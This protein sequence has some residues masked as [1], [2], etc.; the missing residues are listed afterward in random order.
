M[1]MILIQRRFYHTLYMN[2]KSCDRNLK[3][4]L[5][6]GLFCA[7]QALYIHTVHLNFSWV[8]I[9]V[10]VRAFKGENNMSEKKTYFV[11]VGWSLIQG[12]EHC[13][14]IGITSAGWRRAYNKVMNINIALPC[15]GLAHARA[16]EK[17]GQDYLETRTPRAFVKWSPV[18][19]EKSPNRTWDWWI[20]NQRLS[21]N[22]TANV[23]ERMR[24]VQ[25]F[26]KPET[27]KYYMARKL[28]QVNRQQKGVKYGK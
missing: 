28:G 20:S 14:T 23:V 10:P 5:T 8:T 1:R 11:Y 15:S 9:G 22:T 17:S 13:V 12:E 24:N 6:P 18:E 2:V 3:I 21:V 27:H 16:V 25:L 26:W 19:L 7:C 4:N